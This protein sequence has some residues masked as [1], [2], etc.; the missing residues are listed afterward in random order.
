MPTY[1]VFH[2]VCPLME[3]LFDNQ[4]LYTMKPG[5][6]FTIWFRGWHIFHPIPCSHYCTRTL[7][8]V[9]GMS[10]YAMHRTVFPIH[11]IIPYHFSSC[12]VRYIELDHSRERYWIRTGTSLTWPFAPERRPFIGPESEDLPHPPP[13]IGPGW[14]DFT[15]FNQWLV[16]CN[17]FHSS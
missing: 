17:C 12:N 14:E 13:M 8:S 16:L 6:A 9:H 5:L 1:A 15:H 4:V 3:P 10:L 7:Y 11:C 2:F